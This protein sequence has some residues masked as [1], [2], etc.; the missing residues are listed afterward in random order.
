M[1]KLSGLPIDTTPFASSDYAVKVKAGGA[2]D[3]RVPWSSVAVLTRNVHMIKTND[4]TGGVS[5]SQQ[6]ANEIAFTGTPSAYGRLNQLLPMD[7][8]AGT[9]ATLYLMLWSASANNETINYYIGS[10]FNGQTYSAWNVANSLT[11]TAGINLT[12]NVISNFAMATIPAANLVAGCNIACAFKPASAI[13]GTIYVKEAFLQY[14][15]QL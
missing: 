13:T 5:T 3:V 12:A 1:G 10:H 6:E 7:Y 2:G 8:V 11:T 14:T 4:N 15:A 9:N